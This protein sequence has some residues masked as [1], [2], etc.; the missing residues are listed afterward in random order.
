MPST[1]SKISE[2]INSYPQFIFKEAIDFS[3]IPNKKI[4]Y[5]NSTDKQALSLLIHEVSHALLE[6]NQHASDIDLIRI[7]QEAWTFAQ[8]LAKQ[9]N[10]SITDEIIQLN[11]DTYRDWIHK[12]SIC[13]KCRST[14]FQIKATTYK[15]P[16]C[17]NKWLV[18]QAK[19]HRLIRKNIK[20]AH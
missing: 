9:F 2:I 17:D 18:N 13:P 1:I 4:I 16:A 6:H 20:S 14:G 3:W 11:L 5:Y 10:I 15:C 19:D 7:E 12:R 8:N